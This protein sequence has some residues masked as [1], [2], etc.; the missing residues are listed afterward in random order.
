MLAFGSVQ[1]DFSSSMNTISA[2][3]KSL[4]RHQLDVSE[5]NRDVAYF[6]R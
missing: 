4:V 1:E 5:F 6:Y 3:M 2:G